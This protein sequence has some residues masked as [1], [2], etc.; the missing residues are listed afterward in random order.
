MHLL[1]KIL[2]TLWERWTALP[3]AKCCPSCCINWAGYR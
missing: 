3:L 1:A 2:K